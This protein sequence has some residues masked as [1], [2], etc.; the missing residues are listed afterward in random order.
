MYSASPHPKLQVGDIVALSKA[1]IE[2]QSWYAKSM[3]RPRGEVTA[4]LYVDKVILADV[5]WDKPGIPKRINVKNL[6][7][8]KALAPAG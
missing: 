2:R 6:T 8:A 5:E 7:T 3:P 1:F 4:V